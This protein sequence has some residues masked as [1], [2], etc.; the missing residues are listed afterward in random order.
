MDR[1]QRPRFLPLRGA[2]PAAAL[3][4]LGLAAA[5]VGAALAHRDQAGGLGLPLLAG[6]VLLLGAT[7]VNAARR[8]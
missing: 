4:L 7:A 5:T 1:P 6:G 2:D 8:L 3:P